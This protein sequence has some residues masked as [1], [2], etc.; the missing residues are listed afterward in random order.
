MGYR[1]VSGLTTFLLL[2]AVVSVSVG[3]VA[4][5]GAAPQAENATVV[6]NESGPAIATVEPTQAVD[7]GPNG[8]TFVWERIDGERASGYRIATT[9]ASPGANA[10]VCLRANGSVSC[11]PVG[12]DGHVNLS[13]PG[14]DGL[15]SLTVSLS[16]ASSNA[17]L[18]AET[19]SLRPIER[20][21]DLDSDGLNNSDEVES[22][23]NLTTADSDGDGLTDGAEVH[24]YGTD[25]SIADTDEDGLLDAAE[26]RGGSDPTLADTDHDGLVDERELAVGTNPT[27]VDTDGDGLTD[28]REVSGKTDPTVADTDGDGVLDGTELKIGTNPAQADS[29]GDGIADGR[30]RSLGT[31]P[32]V[33]DTDGDGL[34][35]G[36]EL[37]RGTD[38]TVSDTDGDGLADG[39]ELEVGTS[40]LTVDTDSDGLADGTEVSTTGTSPLAADTDGDFLSDQQEVTWGTD[41][42]SALTPAW[43]T[44]AFLGFVVGIGLSVAAIRRGWLTDLSASVRLFVYRTLEFDREIIEVNREIAADDEQNAAPESPMQDAES[45]SDV[46]ERADTEFVPDEQLVTMMLKAESGRMHQSDVVA[47]TDWSK[48]KV[49]RLLS[50]MADDDDIVKIRLGRENLICLERAKPAAASSA[51]AASTAD[52]TPPTPGG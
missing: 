18:D 38:P 16:N 41:P 2:I 14:T 1:I 20:T 8:T 22:G 33:S 11:A 40:P 17:T 12:P 46:F 34:A 3:V 49:S 42:N 27:A 10:S 44:S 30:E 51:H 24:Q 15:A 47:A 23:T 32:T 29:D 19:V 28:Q 7:R 43:V 13:T 6:A 35:D 36:A 45:A 25:P 50:S 4:A 26:V 52:G 5:E 21:G 48:A 39:R 31:N 9:V 37:R